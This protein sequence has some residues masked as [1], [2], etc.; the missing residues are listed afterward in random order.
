MSMSSEPEDFQALRRILVLKRY[1]QPPPGYFNGFS[2]QII[3]RIEAGEAA[4]SSS[5]LTG[6]WSESSWFFR[7]FQAFQTKPILAG[8]FGLSICGMLV[9]GI[10]YSGDGQASLMPTGHTAS[11]DFQL[12]QPAMVGVAQAAPDA[13]LNRLAPAEQQGSLFLQFRDS[14]KP[15][16]VTTP[17]SQVQVRP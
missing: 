5:L 1:E 10:A 12:E 17:V 8:A 13:N 2:R 9:A 15:W 7:A 14:Q 6:V 16:V 4:S 11:T 3:A